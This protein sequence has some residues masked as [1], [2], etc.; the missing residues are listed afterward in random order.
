MLKNT[1]T[2]LCNDMLSS[3]L[4][5]DTFFEQITGMSSSYKSVMVCT[6]DVF[7]VISGYVLQIKTG[8]EV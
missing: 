8:R 1:V 5:H 6:E 7:T 2:W 3:V 4:H